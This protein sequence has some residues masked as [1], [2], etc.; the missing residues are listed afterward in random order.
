[1]LFV[2]FVSLADRKIGKE[3]I[4]TKKSPTSYSGQRFLVLPLGIEPKSKV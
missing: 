2:S 3:F 4:E 1:M